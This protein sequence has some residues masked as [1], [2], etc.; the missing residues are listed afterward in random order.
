MGAFL[1]GGLALGFASTARAQEHPC[2]ADAA[3]LCAGV[4]PGGGAQ[5]A[6]LKAH[7]EQLSPACK[8]KIL[9]KKIEMKEQEELQ[10]E[11]MAPPPQP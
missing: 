2:M 3:R 1:L 4:E 7:Q 10:K 6:C 8:K 11:E 9:Q 5:I